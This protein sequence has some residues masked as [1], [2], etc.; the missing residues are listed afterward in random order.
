MRRFEA[1]PRRPT[2]KGQHPSSPTQ[3]HGQEALPTPS[4]SSTFGTH[5]TPQVLPSVADAAERYLGLRQ[6]ADV[7][8]DNEK[9]ERETSGSEVEG[10]IQKAIGSDGR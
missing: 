3:Q 6:R 5:G 7:H 1:S 9:D 8:P 10:L 2:P 4:S